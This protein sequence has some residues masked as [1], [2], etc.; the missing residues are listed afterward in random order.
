MANMAN[1][2]TTVPSV[3]QRESANWGE[4]NTAFPP[5]GMPQLVPAFG[6]MP[7]RQS[8][9]KVKAQQHAPQHAPQHA[10]QEMDVSESNQNRSMQGMPINIVCTGNRLEIQQTTGNKILL[11]WSKVT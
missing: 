8:Q 2:T 11:F 3:T 5:L 4:Y 10:L 1:N 6:G 7:P 9:N